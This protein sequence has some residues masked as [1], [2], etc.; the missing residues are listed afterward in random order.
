[1]TYTFSA[2]KTQDEYAEV[3]ATF[4]Y[5]ENIVFSLGE[6]SGK[7][8][9]A[10]VKR[11][12]Q[13]RNARQEKVKNTIVQLLKQYY[14]ARGLKTVKNHTNDGQFRVTNE[15]SKPSRYYEAESNG[16]HYTIKVSGQLTSSEHLEDM[17][18]CGIVDFELAKF[19]GAKK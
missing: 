2:T 10:T 19:F 16:T 8:W 7:K 3:R 5:I 9:Q 4:S 17:L 11:V 15:N 14:N 12:N 1:M 13:Q 6:K 18:D